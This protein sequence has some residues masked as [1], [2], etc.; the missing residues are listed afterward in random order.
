[1]IC[2][3]NHHDDPDRSG[4]WTLPPAP[5]RGQPP[6]RPFRWMLALLAA[7]GAVVVLLALTGCDEPAPRKGTAEDRAIVQ[8]ADAETSQHDA[9]AA[10]LDAIQ[11]DATADN[12]EATATLAAQDAQRLG[13]PAA[14]ER[15]A[16]AR[17]AAAEARAAATTARAIADAQQRQA[18]RSATAAQ[19][20]A[21]E[22]TK[23]R[24][25][26]AAIDRQ[27]RIQTWCDWIGGACV[28]LGIAAGF[29]VAYLVRPLYGGLVGALGLTLGIAAPLFGA[30]LPWIEA[31]APWLLLAFAAAVVL[32]AWWCAHHARDLRTVIAA[33]THD[34]LPPRLARLAHRHGW[35]APRDDDVH[36]FPLEQP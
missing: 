25:K 12:A 11:A 24:Q 1:M 28:L 21:Q 5:R 32:G 35:A 10:D 7:I 9:D 27:Q 29:L 2:H 6:R 33:P 23:E 8:Q 4:I 18:T 14:I 34:D 31:A 22:A 15:A 17:V 19:T 26:Q 3:L 16:A 30:S 13:T 20:A 36:P